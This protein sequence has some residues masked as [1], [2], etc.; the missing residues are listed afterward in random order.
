[1]ANT[2]LAPSSLCWE[3]GMDLLTCTCLEV[4]LELGGVDVR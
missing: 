3:G 2:A 1:M 4:R